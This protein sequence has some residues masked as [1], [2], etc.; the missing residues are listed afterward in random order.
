MFCSLAHCRCQATE[1]H[2][3]RKDLLQHRTSYLRSTHGRR[4]T[5]MRFFR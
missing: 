4:V 5:G 1:S 2:E 3:N